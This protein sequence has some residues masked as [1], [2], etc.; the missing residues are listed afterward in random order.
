MAERAVRFGHAMHFLAAPD[1]GPGVVEGIDH[2]GG[3]PLDHRPAGPSASGE[4]DPAHRQ[5]IALVA[6]D[7]YRHLVGRAAHPLRRYLNCRRHIAQ[8]GIEDLELCPAQALGSR[9]KRTIY[10]YI[11]RVFLHA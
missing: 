3:Q 9:V 6:L 7:L 8:R 5:R 4:D 1:R 10:N 11:V 2:L